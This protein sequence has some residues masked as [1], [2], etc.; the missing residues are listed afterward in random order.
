MSNV[1]TLL[2]QLIQSPSI[3]P[4][5]HGCQTLIATRLKKQGFTIEHLPKNGVSNLWARF[6]QTAPLLVFAGH[7]DVVPPGDKNDWQT[8]PFQLTDIDDTLYGRGTSDMKGG[9]AAM[10]CA[11]EQFLTHHPA[12]PFSIAFL[13]TSDEEGPAEFGTKTVIETLEARG[14]KI[15]YCVLAEPTSINKLGDSIKIGRR[16]SL[17]GELTII[18]KQGHVAIAEKA[19]NPIHASVS[20]LT[21]FTTQTWD[22][23]PSE[24]FPATSL[25]ISNIHAGAGVFNVIPGNLTLKFNFRFPP[26][27]SPDQLK[28]NLNALLKQHALNY[29]LTWHAPA[30]PYLTDANTPFVKIAINAVEKITHTPTKL[31]TNGGASD[32]RFIAPT[33]AH[34]IEIGLLNHSIH[35]VNEHTTKN[36]LLQLVQVF[37]QLLINLS[38]EHQENK[39]T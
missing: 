13:L 35:Q 7:T 39:K 22:D 16:G 27:T 1:I 14:E 21:A 23:Q 28:T 2:K 5:D 9:V 25:Q 34:V 32:G 31:A 15:D 26:Q 11:V 6:G 17:N 18:G 36:D 4:D 33:G 8:D 37:E 30:I 20:F 24:I 29:H 10:L 38:I 12:P 3:T 19:L